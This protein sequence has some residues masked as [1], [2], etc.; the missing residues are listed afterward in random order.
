MDRQKKYTKPA[1]K[2]SRSKGLHLDRNRSSEIANV[3]ENMS[4]QG[5]ITPLLLLLLTIS[6][7]CAKY[8]SK[9]K[10]TEFTT[11]TTA[12]PNR[13]ERIEDYWPVRVFNC[14]GG[15]GLQKCLKIFLVKR[16]DRVEEVIASG[17][18]VS[19]DFDVLDEIKKDFQWEKYRSLSDGELDGQ[20]MKSIDDVFLKKNTTLVLHPGID[21]DI[22]PDENGSIVLNF[23]KGEFKF[24]IKKNRNFSLAIF[25]QCF[26]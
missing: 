21:V 20:L 4:A 5:S 7:S 24:H 18:D 3:A 2:S 14:V 10:E 13:T 19:V 26:Q 6:I 15:A 1:N 22:N 25:L 9:Y 16:L 23:K 11:S 12:R 17:N 8:S